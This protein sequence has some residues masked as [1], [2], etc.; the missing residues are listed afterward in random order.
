MKAVMPW[1]IAEDHIL[2]KYLNKYPQTIPETAIRNKKN[3][4]SLTGRI[5]NI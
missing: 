2:L 5:V 4:P 1:D 3:T